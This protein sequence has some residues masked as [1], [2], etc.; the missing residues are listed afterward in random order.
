VMQ[1]G[2]QCCSSALCTVNLLCVSNNPV[3]RLRQLRSVLQLAWAAFSL[4][5][6]QCCLLMLHTFGFGSWSCKRQ[7]A[8]MCVFG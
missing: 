2:C 4:L 8:M 6:Q 1:Q 7:S 5:Q 3:S